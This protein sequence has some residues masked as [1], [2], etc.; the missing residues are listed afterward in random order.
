MK[1]LLVLFCIALSFAPAVAR[2]KG[3][4]NLDS[5]TFDKVVGGPY[6]VLVRFDKEYPVLN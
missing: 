5:L 3:I 2:D 4:L 6:P 1:I